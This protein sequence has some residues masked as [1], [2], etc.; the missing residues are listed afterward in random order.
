MAINRHRNHP[1]RK[2]ET[3]NLS[4]ISR[5]LFKSFHIRRLQ[6]LFF[7]SPLQRGT[8]RFPVRHLFEEPN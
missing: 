5:F 1:H 3:Y 4:E 7:F 6:N 8:R 2:E